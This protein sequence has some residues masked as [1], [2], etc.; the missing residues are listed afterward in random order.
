MAVIIAGPIFLR[1]N[2]V[3]MPVFSVHMAM[4]VVSVDVP[5]LILAI[6]VVVLLFLVVVANQLQALIDGEARLRDWR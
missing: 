1:I 5:V 4:P 6:A 3:T 2:P